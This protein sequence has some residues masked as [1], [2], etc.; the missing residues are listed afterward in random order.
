A[1]HSVSLRPAPA[2]MLQRLGQLA[3]SLPDLEAAHRLE[4]ENIRILDL[5]G[6]ARLA[7]EQPA[8]SEKVLRQALAKAPEDPE[9]VMHMGRALM[10][11]GGDD[12]DQEFMERSQ[13]ILRTGLT[14]V[15]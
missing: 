1:P 2:W 14:T 7:L 10:D 15:W 5:M 8:E 4:P 13:K 9:V 6:L 12:E 11:L 3:E